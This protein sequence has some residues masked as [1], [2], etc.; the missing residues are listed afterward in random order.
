MK[1]ND[2]TPEELELLEKI[3]QA[4]EL[5]LDNF[6]WRGKPFVEKRRDYDTLK[7]LKQDAQ[8]ARGTKAGQS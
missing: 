5:G 6:D 1:T 7:R 4:A 2:F 3:A 8:Q